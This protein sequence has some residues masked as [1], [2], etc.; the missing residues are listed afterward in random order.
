MEENRD[1]GERFYSLA[2]NEQG[3]DLNPQTRR[4]IEAFRHHAFDEESP[5]IDFQH[6]KNKKRTI[7]TDFFKKIQELQ[8]EQEL[9]GRGTKDTSII[10]VEPAARKAENLKKEY[11]KL[12]ET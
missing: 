5:I 1:M 3:V 11:F 4:I 7:L 9:I 8:K 6:P 12:K 10:E 2:E